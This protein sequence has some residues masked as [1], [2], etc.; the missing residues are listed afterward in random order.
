MKNRKRPGFIDVQQ[1]YVEK[2]LLDGCNALPNIDI[3][4]GHRVEGVTPL[5]NGVDLAV[6]TNGGSYALRAGWAV[7]CDESRSTACGCMG[8]DFD[9]RVVEDSFLIADIGMKHAMPPERWFWFDPPFNPGQ[10]AGCRDI[11]IIRCTARRAGA[12][13]ASSTS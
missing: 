3:R 2:Y 5:C 7:A 13:T 9:G 11:S 12:A 8:P 10:G 4:W 6:A 1:Y